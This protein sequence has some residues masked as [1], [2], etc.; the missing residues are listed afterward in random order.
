[1]ARLT[2]LRLHT[3]TYGYSYMNLLVPYPYENTFEVRLRARRLNYFHH[4]QQVDCC[5]R[6]ITSVSITF[7]NAAAIDSVPAGGGIQDVL[8]IDAGCPVACCA[9][10]NVK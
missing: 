8:L 10:T 2:V 9:N 1:M 5:P 4:H 7:A 3:R 6:H